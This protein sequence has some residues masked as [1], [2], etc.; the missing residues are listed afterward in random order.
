MQLENQMLLSPLFLL[1]FLDK[2]MNED[3]TLLFYGSL[4]FNPIKPCGI[5]K[6]FKYCGF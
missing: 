3:L 4:R 5:E 1:W 6:V 2:C